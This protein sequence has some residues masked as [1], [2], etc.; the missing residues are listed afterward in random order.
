MNNGLQ[1]PALIFGIRDYG[2]YTINVY[3]AH[4]LLLIQVWVEYSA[5]VCTYYVMSSEIRKSTYCKMS[6]KWYTCV[7]TLGPEV[8]ILILF[9]PYIYIYIKRLL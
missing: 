9:I 4:I 6:F 3:F 1:G 2:R 8:A 5:K 7:F